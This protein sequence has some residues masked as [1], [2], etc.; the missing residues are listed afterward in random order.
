MV[1]VLFVGTHVREG[2]AEMFE[3]F[4]VLINVYFGKT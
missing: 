4:N 1:H 3:V 2:N